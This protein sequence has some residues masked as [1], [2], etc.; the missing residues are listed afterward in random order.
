MRLSAL[1]AAI[2]FGQTLWHGFLD[3]DDFDYVLN[4]PHVREGISIP[5][6]VWAFTPDHVAN[7][8][9][10]TWISHML[11][12]QLY[13]MGRGDIISQRALHVANAML[14]FLV[15]RRM[16][17]G[18]GSSAWWRPVCASIRCGW[19]RW[20]GWPSGRTC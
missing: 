12:C 18:L 19:S 7:W 15:L 9:P 3:L 5:G 13:G 2:V 1:L 20:P 14:L 4:N 10:L 11:D 6:L 16:T 8:H 17:G